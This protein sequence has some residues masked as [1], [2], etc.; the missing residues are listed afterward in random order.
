MRARVKLALAVFCA[1][2]V[3]QGICVVWVHYAETGRPVGVFVS[4]ALE[5]FAL[6]CGIEEGIKDRWVAAAWILGCGVG[7]ALMVALRG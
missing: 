5:A 7:P 1:G 2:A 3:N 4:G 6:L